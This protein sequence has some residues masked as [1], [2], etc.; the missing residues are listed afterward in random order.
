MQ[1]KSKGNLVAMKAGLLD[2]KTLISRLTFLAYRAKFYY[3]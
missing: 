2:S 1:T 3:E